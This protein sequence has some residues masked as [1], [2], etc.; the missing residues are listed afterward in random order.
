MTYIS[1]GGTGGWQTN[2][3]YGEAG[4]Q[5]LGPATR[6]H[7]AGLLSGVAWKAR[8]SP[9]PHAGRGLRESQTLRESGRPV[10]AHRQ[11]CA[12]FRVSAP[13]WSPAESVQPGGREDSQ[14]E[15][16]NLA[17]HPS[18]FSF[19]FFFNIDNTQSWLPPQ[20]GVLKFTHPTQQSSHGLLTRHR[21]E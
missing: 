16:G 18:F 20:R 19:F 10:S 3:L 12:G 2:M 8:P 21:K 14:R 11:P 4:V 5:A 1:C 17:G 13:G 15:G 9:S 6:Q 7:R